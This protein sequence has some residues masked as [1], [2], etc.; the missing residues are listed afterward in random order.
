MPASA[1]APDWQKRTGQAGYFVVVVL[2]ADHYRGI[3]FQ[4]DESC[5]PADQVELVTGVHLRSEL[6]LGDGDSI[7]FVLGPDS[8]P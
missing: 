2:I 4:G 6:A 3:A 1:I 5:Y 7:S 8:P